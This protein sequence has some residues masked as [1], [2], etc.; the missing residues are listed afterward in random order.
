M[1]RRAALDYLDRAIQNHGEVYQYLTVGEIRELIEALCSEMQGLMVGD[2]VR[3]DGGYLA[4]EV[5]IVLDPAVDCDTACAA[6]Y[7]T[8]NASWQI[9]YGKRWRLRRKEVEHGD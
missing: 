8:H 4:G 1:N 9:W 2:R 3:I 5:G 6:V 7:N